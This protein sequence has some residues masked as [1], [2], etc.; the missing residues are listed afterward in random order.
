MKDIKPLQMV[1]QVKDA[2]LEAGRVIR[3][4]W[5]KPKK[6]THKGRI[7]LVTETDVAVE[8]L[9]KSSLGAILPEADFWAEETSNSDKM[10]KVCWI[11][12][13]VDGTTNFT[14]SLPSVATS[15]A[16]W[17][18]EKV[19]LGVINLPILDEC[20]WAVKNSGA[21]LNGAKISVSGTE[22]LEESL[23]ATG[24]PYD[25]ETYVDQVGK[26]LRSFLLNTQG[27][28][29]VGAAALDMAYVACGR[30]DGF[31]ESALNPWDV[32]AGWLLVEEAGGK[33]SNYDQEPFTLTSEHLLASN[34]IIHS[35]MSK[36]LIK[37]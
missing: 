24:F 27:V 32:A 11:I 1:D 16:L 29:R 4:A 7:D 36:L 25:I 20:F 2:V 33:V 31:Y 22:K 26:N 10:D 9:L 23:I 18:T 3:E 21:Y 35:S 34:K 5:T 28:R 15:V 6:I 14:H 19:V 12:D 37:T 30:Y 17:D 13:P 8:N